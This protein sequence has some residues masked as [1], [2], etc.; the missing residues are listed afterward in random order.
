MQ[1]FGIG[2]LLEAP[3]PVSQAWSNT[4]WRVQTASG[5]YAIKLFPQLSPSRRRALD[6]GILFERL[7]IEDGRI[8]VPKPVASAGGWL[9]ELSSTSGPRVVRCHEWVTGAAPRG[10]LGDKAID[11]AGRYLGVLHAMRRPGGDT[12]R[13]DRST[14]FAGLSPSSVRGTGSSGGPRSWLSS[15]LSSRAWPPISMPFALSAD[16]CS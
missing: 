11:A 4:V 5:A 1:S 14:S 8:P 3:V 13:F 7:V 15:P 9:V 12:S 2:P 16:K 6:A 10:P